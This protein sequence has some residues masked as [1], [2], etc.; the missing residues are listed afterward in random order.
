MEKIKTNSG[1]EI[2]VDERITDD[3]RLVC[4]LSELESDDV[5]RKLSGIMNI[6]NLVLGHDGMEALQEHIKS[7]NDGFI[8]T[9]LFQK[10]V[11][12]ILTSMKKGKK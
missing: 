8:P 3:W 4:A 6:S 1:F 2:D 7:Q 11:I 10:E 12:E 5:K 9:G